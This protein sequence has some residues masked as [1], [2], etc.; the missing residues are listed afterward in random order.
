[1]LFFVTGIFLITTIYV[2][3]K[4]CSGH[5]ATQ[6]S[7]WAEHVCHS[8]LGRLELEMKRDIQAAAVLY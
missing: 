1:M 2:S 8:H 6:W 3:F 5:S 4:P 7:I